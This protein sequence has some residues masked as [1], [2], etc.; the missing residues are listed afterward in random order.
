MNA[1][2]LDGLANALEPGYNVLDAAAPLLRAHHRW[3]GLGQSDLGRRFLNGVALPLAMA[4]KH[5]VDDAAIRRIH[6]NGKGAQHKG[7]AALVV[8]G[9]EAP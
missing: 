7:T 6:R 1:L 2:C 8:R 4:R 9:P 3:R 5:R